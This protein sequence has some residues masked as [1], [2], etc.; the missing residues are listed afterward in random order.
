MIDKSQAIS[1]V[2]DRLKDFENETVGRL[3]IVDEHTIEC[4]FGWVFSWDSKRHLE[5]GAISD[6]LAGNAPF[7]VDRRDGSIH[8]TGTA[9][10]VE[11]YI[12]EYEK[13]IQSR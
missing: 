4:S 11:H 13:K 2:K 12:A 9:Y 10:P 5:T 8:D 7:I 6:A 1:I 3:E